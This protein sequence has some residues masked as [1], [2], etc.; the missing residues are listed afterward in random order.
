M[1]FYCF[2]DVY[3]EEYVLGAY[4]LAIKSYNEVYYFITVFNYY[5]DVSKSKGQIVD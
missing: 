3:I 2:K 4:V 5:F 1:F